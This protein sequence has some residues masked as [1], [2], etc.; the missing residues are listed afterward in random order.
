MKRESLLTS[1]FA[2][3]VDIRSLGK[4]RMAGSRYF[5]AALTSDSVGSMFICL[6]ER[7]RLPQNNL[8]QDQGFLRALA[9]QSSGGTFPIGFLA[10]LDCSGDRHESASCS[11]AD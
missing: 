1:F 3:D 4:W 6:Q 10:Q 5:S 8:R 9:F 7:T 2:A 11:L